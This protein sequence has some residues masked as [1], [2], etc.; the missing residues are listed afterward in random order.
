[1]LG[2]LLK[3][4]FMT[5]GKSLSV[6][7]GVLAAAVG[8]MILAHWIGR[9]AIPEPVYLT[10]C[11]LCTISIIIAF[12]TCFIYLCFHFYQSMYSEQGYLTHTLPLK[13]GQ[14]LNVKV[15]V[16]CGHLLLAEILTTLSFAVI[17]APKDRIQLG[18]LADIVWQ[19]IHTMAH[20]TKIPVAALIFF[21]LFFMILGTLD[22]LLLFF[23]G[24]SIGQLSHRSKGAY[25]I[26]ASIGL[27]YA[28]QIASLVLVFIGYLLHER[29]FQHMEPIWIVA[30]SG[31][32]VSCWAIVHYMICRVIVQKH[33]NLE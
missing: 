13:T 15:A 12:V 6:L 21:F 28:T 2:K 4:E 23:A 24:S 26:A 19:A 14:I 17:T 3:H 25:G 1:M 11:V 33:L 8:F 31:A 22:S 18:A 20:E 10:L 7:Y 16:S 5:Q 32:L 9:S 27:Y 29:L 30:G